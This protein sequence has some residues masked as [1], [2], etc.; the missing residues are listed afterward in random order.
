M[1]CSKIHNTCKEEHAAHPHLQLNIHP[2]LSDMERLGHT[3]A[4]LS[5]ML[6]REKNV[7]S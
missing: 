6:V 3:L 1:Q 4:C 7:P 5:Y 2:V